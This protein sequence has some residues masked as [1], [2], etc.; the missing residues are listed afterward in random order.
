MK[1]LLIHKINS[2]KTI[3]QNVHSSY[4]ALEGAKYRCLEAISLLSPLFNT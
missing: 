2:L 1:K 3:S 4:L